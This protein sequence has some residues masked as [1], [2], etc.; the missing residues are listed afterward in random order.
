L[1]VYTAPHFIEKTFYSIDIGSKILTGFE[2]YFDVPFPL[3][4]LDLIGI[5]DFKQ[6]NGKLGLDYI[7]R[8]KFSERKY[9]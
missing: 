8:T 4:K 7:L 1:R 3:K 5:P 6:W 2:K 9:F